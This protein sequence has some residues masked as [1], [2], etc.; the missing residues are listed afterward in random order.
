MNIVDLLK[1][2]SVKS[3]SKVSMLAKMLEEE[4]TLVSHIIDSE[5]SLKDV[6]I[7]TFLESLEHVSAT[8]P[9]LVSIEAIHFAERQ[10]QSKASR[11]KWESAKLIANTISTYPD[12]VDSIVPQLLTNVYDESTVVRWSVAMALVQIYRLNLPINKDLI[13]EIGK[14]M[15]KE[16]KNSILKIYDKALK[17][18]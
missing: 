10:L 7:A 11:V 13:I 14:I 6:E 3:K 9:H 17:K 4:P 16:D 8:N 5:K 18:K 2:K 12:R 15:S 1:D